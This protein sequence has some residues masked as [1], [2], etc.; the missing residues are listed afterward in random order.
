MSL[1]WIYDNG[2]FMSSVLHLLSLT[3]PILTGPDPLKSWIRIHFGSGSKT[4][5]TGR[6]WPK[7]G[8]FIFNKNY[9]FFFCRTFL[10]NQPY[11][12][13][14]RSPQLG[15]RYEAR[16]EIVAE[17][18]QEFLARLYQ[19][20]GRQL[21][22]AGHKDGVNFKPRVRPGRDSCPKNQMSPKKCFTY[23]LCCVCEA[24]RFFKVQGYPFC[25]LLPGPGESLLPFPHSHFLV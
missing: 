23:F 2:E 25:S 22:V 3:Y 18:E 9:I 15:R 11:C 4:L 24:R 5:S 14:I 19:Y 6:S 16:V 10:P 12:D 21:L 7:F 13:V 17:Q 20:L 8:S 1:W